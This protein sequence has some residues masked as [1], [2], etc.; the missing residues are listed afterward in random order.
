MLTEICQYLH[1][2]FERE[3]IIG[4]LTFKDNL[5]Y[6]KDGDQVVL[7][8]DQY[9]RVI[10]SMLNDG[11]H[12]YPA[13]LK[14]ETFEG[15]VWSMAV[16]PDFVLLL[17]EIEAWQTKYGGA[18]STAMSPFNSE[19]FAGYSYSKGGTSDGAGVTWMSTFG[20]RLSAWRKI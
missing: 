16:P 14:D 5:I 17:Q 4:K 11:V 18:D 2:W 12:K 8:D 1:N 6:T 19:S 20:S 15:A 9:F 3:K 7:L 13:T 10:G